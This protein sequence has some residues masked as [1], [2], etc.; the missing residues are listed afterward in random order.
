MRAANVARA[1]RSAESLAVVGD[2]ADGP[3]GLLRLAV[4]RRG[5]PE[6]DRV[7]PL[8]SAD[9]A[10]IAALRDRIL[11][12]VAGNRSKTAG[13]DRDQALAALALAAESLIGASKPDQAGKDNQ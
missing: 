1:F 10:R 6:R 9:Q 13:C 8:R 4:A 3:Q 7:L 5:H 2:G 11:D 12:A